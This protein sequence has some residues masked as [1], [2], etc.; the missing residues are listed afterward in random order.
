MAMLSWPDACGGTHLLAHLQQGSCSAHAYVSGPFAARV[1][2]IWQTTPARA[3]RVAGRRR[4]TARSRARGRRPVSGRSKP[5]LLR[6]R[7]N[8]G[9][10]AKAVLGA[11]P[12]LARTGARQG[13]RCGGVLLSVRA[14]DVRRLQQR[15]ISRKTRGANASRRLDCKMGCICS[16][17]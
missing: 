15:W 12:K 6:L 2:S 3:I 11:A 4:E 9:L 5:F 7:T 16:A 13:A 8:V 1:A 17:I 14:N 10:G